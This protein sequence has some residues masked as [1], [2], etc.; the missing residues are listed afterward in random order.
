MSALVAAQCGSLGT[1]SLP[2]EEGGCGSRPA[3]TGCQADPHAI[4]PATQEQ[5]SGQA[6]RPSASQVFL[7]RKGPSRKL[8][9]GLAKRQGR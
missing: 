8:T 9:D 3:A 2:S 4:L 7:D 6:L 1:G 5:G